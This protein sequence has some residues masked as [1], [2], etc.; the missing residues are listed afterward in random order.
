MDE[1]KLMNVEFF[2]RRIL[3]QNDHLKKAIDNKITLRLIVVEYEDG[4]F[5]EL[6]QNHDK[7]AGYH[8]GSVESSCYAATV[9]VVACKLFIHTVLVVFISTDISKISSYE[10]KL[11]E[12]KCS[13]HTKHRIHYILANVSV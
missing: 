10:M 13:E 1:K 4:R 3:S 2:L 9:S 11:F 8:I 5:V 6:S 7:F 12:K